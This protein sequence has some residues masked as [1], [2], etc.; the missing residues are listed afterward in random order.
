[1]SCTLT[2]SGVMSLVHLGR[3]RAHHAQDEQDIEDVAAHHVADG[4]VVLPGER[5]AHRHRHLGRTRAK[6][7]HGEPDDQ[8]RHAE[9]QGELGRA[10]H[11]RARTQDQQ[12]QT[13]QKQQE[14]H[15]VA[16][17]LARDARL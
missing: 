1:M 3:E 12:G 17:Q 14:V 5:G 4:D 7:H 6:G 11:Q 16:V 8:W 9:R 2:T 13:A 10:A 15:R